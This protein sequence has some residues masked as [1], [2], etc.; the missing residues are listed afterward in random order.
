M[1]RIGLGDQPFLV[2]RHN[3]AGHQ[4]LHIATVSI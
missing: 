3:D 1:E 4:H 2:Y